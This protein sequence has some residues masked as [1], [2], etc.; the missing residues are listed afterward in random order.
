[1]NGVDGT[2]VESSRVE[3][4]VAVG[5]PLSLSAYVVAFEQAKKQTKVRS[6]RV[7]KTECAAGRATCFESGLRQGLDTAG[8]IARLPA[9]RAPRRA[10]DA[11]S[12]LLTVGPFADRLLTT[13]FRG[14]SDGVVE[15]VE[16]KKS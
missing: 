2:A 14:T 3:S 6:S 13:S 10:R 15:P 4:R 7:I 12:S 8:W 9:S 5:R 1:M 11:R 16:Q